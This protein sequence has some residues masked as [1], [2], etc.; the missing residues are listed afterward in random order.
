MIDPSS[1][2]LRG[3]GDAHFAQSLVYRPTSSDEVAACLADAQHRQLTVAHRGA[4]QSYGDAALNQGGAVID[5][6]KLRRIIDFDMERGIITAEAGVTVG[7]LWQHVVPHGWW[8]PVVP[9]TMHTTL[10]GCLAMNVHGKNNAQ[11]GPIG[12]HVRALTL[13]EPSGSTTSLATNEHQEGLRRVIGAQGLT[14]TILDVT[15]Q[16]KRVHSGYVEVRPQPVRSLDAALERLDAGIRESDYSVGWLDCFAGGRRMGRGVLHFAHHLPPD[17]TL[18]GQG[19][20]RTSQEL[21]GK[22]LGLLP[23]RHAWRFLRA[24]ATNPGVRALNV[25]KNLGGIVAGTRPY[26]QSH[27]AFHFLLDYMPN[28]KRMYRPHGLIQYQFFVPFEA[29]PKTF[30]AALELQHRTGV[31]SYLAVLKRHRVDD[32]AASYSVDGFSLAL[33]FPLRPAKIDA[34]A[35][36]C[37]EFDAL[38]KDCGGHIYAAK[39]S[40]SCGE[41]PAERHPLFSSNLVRRWEWTENRGR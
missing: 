39:D 34:L 13:L 36:L 33:D 23:K 17:H 9:G 10:G 4:G 14:G 18:A 21:P 24:L 12:E 26:S 15:L 35:R 7:Q 27:A 8:P 6:A 28:W 30:K 22:V 31:I 3:W 16:L 41:L 2:V 38:Q 29:A 40:V 19:L 11:A 5:L 37:R 1:E 25:A 32:S 20:D